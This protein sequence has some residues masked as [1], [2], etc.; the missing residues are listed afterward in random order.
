MPMDKSGSA[1][2][3]GKNYKTE[4]AAGKPKKQALAIALSEQRAHAKGKVKSKLEA[5]YAK[6]MESKCL[7]Y[8]PLK[9]KKT[10]ANKKK[11]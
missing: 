2:S 3:V 9:V 1:Q 5:A 11:Q 6:H 8:Q 10:T 7:P 4:V